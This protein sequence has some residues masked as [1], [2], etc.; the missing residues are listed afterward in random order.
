MSTEAKNCIENFSYTFKLA[1]NFDCVIIQFHGGVRAE[2]FLLALENI[3]QAPDYGS[4]FNRLI[5]FR[6]A[7]IEF[8]ASDIAAMTSWAQTKKYTQ[9][10]R[11]VVHIA[12]ND[13]DFGM[14]RMLMAHSRTFS[15]QV[16]VTRNEDEAHAWVGLT[17]N[18]SPTAV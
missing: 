16:L 6:D 8:S 14:L 1:P 9:Q 12:Q 18:A 7:S 13:A 3:E 2:N 17:S 10:N 11:K 15:N 5:D 4:S